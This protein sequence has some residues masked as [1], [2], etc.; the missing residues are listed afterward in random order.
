MIISLVHRLLENMQLRLLWLFDNVFVFGLENVKPIISL[1]GSCMDQ[2]QYV[3]SSI[4]FET[5][6]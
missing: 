3:E 6:Q 5:L 1:Y 4:E 2:V